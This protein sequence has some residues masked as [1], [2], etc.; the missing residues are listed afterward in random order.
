ML[1]LKPNLMFLVFLHR[2][3]GDALPNPQGCCGHETDDR[4]QLT[5]LLRSAVVQSECI[6]FLHTWLFSESRTPR[7]SD[8]HGREAELFIYHVLGFTRKEIGSFQTGPSIGL[9]SRNG[10][11][12]SFLTG[13]DPGQVPSGTLQVDLLTSGQI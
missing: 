12:S 13:R 2:Y 7:A 8:K 6:P 11:P 5:E 3:N 9:S 10:T 4:E 1:A